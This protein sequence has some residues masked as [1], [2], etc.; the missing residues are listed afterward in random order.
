MIPNLPADQ[1][2][3]ISGDDRCAD[4]FLDPVFDTAADGDWW[5][6]LGNVAIPGIPGM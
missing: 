1:A 3:Q 6:D 4:F 2:L 5:L